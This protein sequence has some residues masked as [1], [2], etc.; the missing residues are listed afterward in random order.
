MTLR[1]ARIVGI[2]SLPRLQT[3]MNNNQN[4]SDS[5]YLDADRPIERREQD[6]LG[7]RS[8]AEAIARQVCA[9][10]AEHGF[11][12]SVEGEWGSGKTS[13]LN[14]VAEALENSQTA[15][16]VLHFNPWL[17]SNADDLVARFFHELS[18]QLGLIR[19]EK[20]KVV[21]KALAKLGQSLAPLSPVSGTT[22]AANLISKL[23]DHWAK[24]PS[25]D[26]MRARLRE[27]LEASDS[28][29]VVLIDDIDRLEPNETRELMRLVRLTSELPNVVFLL[30]FD[31][32]H[33][34]KSLGTNEIEGRQYLDK[35]VQV[36]HDLPAVREAVLPGMLLPWLDEIIR[37][38]DLVQL[39]RDVWGRVFYEIIKPLL[40]NLRDVKRYLYS[41]PVTLDTIGE[42][43]AMADL[44]GLEAIRV[45]RPSMFDELR[46]HNEC[47]VHSNSGSLLWM[48]EEGRNREIQGRLSAMLE[49]AQ[50]E[51]KVLNAVLEILFPV[52]QGFLG[53]GQYG[54]SWIADWRKQRRVACEE[55]LRIYLQAGLDEGA[56]ASRDVQ[57]IVE[58]LTDEKKLVSLFD[59]LD[60]RRFEAALERL[61]DYEHDFPVEA[62]TIA[63]P[64]LVNRMGKLSPHP[65]DMLG[66]SPQVKSRRV[67]LR[68][69]MRFEASEHLMASMSMMVDKVD[70]LSGWF[71]LIEMVGHRDS[72]GHKLVGE[73]QARE[74]EDQFLDRLKSATAEQLVDEWNLFGLLLRTL[75]RLEGEDKARLAERLRDHLAEDE[76]VLTL[77]RTSV[78]YAHYNGHTEKR[79]F[80]DELV[81]V[82]GDSLSDAVQRLNR[83]PLYRHLPEQDQDTINLAQKYVSG[84]HPKA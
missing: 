44:L 72:V 34:A 14:M 42:E 74:L 15:T 10:P 77:L 31:R 30:A 82:F 41:L 61:E 5:S 8:F 64:V 23:T 19:S 67:V 17:F 9:V 37:G 36:S 55:V 4:T 43:V 63:I 69:L 6:R 51:R 58:A 3:C 20:L 54:L 59:A 71:Q 84:W 68:L 53:H 66:F 2:L 33:V 35:I 7:R 29:V 57:G 26:G 27:A 70:T 11:T 80:W 79:I 83:S 60:E 46:F 38:R 62:A 48:T 65:G 49:R 25:L 12:I 47:L 52:T 76:F 81:E 28:R 21:A 40:H 56:I 50:G 1:C 45:F 75:I 22:G 18:A 39:D 16:A 24:P 73:D 13:V 78:N 32:G